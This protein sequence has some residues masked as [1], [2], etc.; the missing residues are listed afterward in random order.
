MPV[1]DAFG[2][3]VMRLEETPV[4]ARLRKAPGFAIGLTVDRKEARDVARLRYDELK[5]RG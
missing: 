1:V 4:F 5:R 3:A 2:R